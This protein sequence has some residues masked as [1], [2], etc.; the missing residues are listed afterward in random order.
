MMAGILNENLGPEGGRLQLVYLI[1][2]FVEPFEDLLSF[3]FVGPPPITWAC[4][5]SVG[6]IIDGR[7]R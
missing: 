4:Y 1:L 3:D 6:I 7:L 5:Q 2:I